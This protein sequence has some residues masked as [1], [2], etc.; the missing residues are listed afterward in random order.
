MPSSTFAFL[1][2]SF[3]WAFPWSVFTLARPGPDASPRA[4]WRSVIVIWLL[5]VVGLFALSRFKHEYYALPAFPALAVLVGGAWASGRDIRRWLVIG[6]TGCSA[7]GLGALWARGRA[8]T[9]AGAQWPGRAE[10]LLSHLARPGDPLPVRV[11]PS[12]RRS[13]EG[14]GAGPARGLGVGDVLLGTRLAPQRVH[15]AR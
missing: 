9:R 13:L 15:L 3:L 12:V 14:A 5:V 10:R 2:A 7:V 11:A 1:V 4:R 6:L 8:D